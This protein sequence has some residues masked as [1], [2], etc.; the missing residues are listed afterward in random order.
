MERREFVKTMTAAG[1]GL[2]LPGLA[3]RAE[4]AKANA[5]VKRVLVMFKCHFDAGFI[6]TQYNVVHKR[7]F[8][9]FFPE[10]IEIARNANAGGKRRY[11]WTTGSWLVYE[12]LE[13]ASAA[14]RKTME[15]ALERGDIAWHG[16]P[17]TWQTEMISPSMI[18]G[19]VALARSL[20]R[21]FG[22]KTTGAKMTD[23]PGHTRGIVTPLARSGI[24]FLEIG[25]NDGSTPAELPPLFL[26]KDP[27]GADLA[28]MYHH[29]YGGVAV[30]PGAELAL[31]TAV[32]G[33]NSGPHTP[34]EIAKIYAE[35]AAQF[36]HAQISAASLSEMADALE[37]YRD[38]LPVV[39]Q[40]IGDTW[41]HGCASDPLKVARY[42]A[43]SR[44]RDAWIAQGKLQ[45]GDATDVN[46]LRHVLLEAEHTWGTDTKTWLDFDNYE[47]ADLARMLDTKNYK[48]VEFS[49]IEKRQDLLDG[50]MTLPEALR[51][52]AQLAVAGVTPVW[53]VASAKAVAVE[54]GKTIETAHF[55]LTID[56]KTGAI[57]TLRSKAS[58][59]EWA[60]TTNPIA[61]MT[62]QTL[63]P[64]DYRRFLSSYLTT[65]ADWAQKDFG[66]PNI[67]RYGA[68][69]EE[70]H[71]QRA[72]VTV[73]E[74]EGGHRV[75]VA[76]AF[77]DED[78]FRSGRAAF[79]QYAFVE[80]ELPQDEA[81][82]RLAVSWFG[83]PATR[84]PEALW[85]T[86]NP[87]VEDV[88]LWSLD[89]SGEAVSPF[90]VV[91]S[92][93]RHMHAV[94]KGFAHKGGSAQFAVE[95]LDAPVVALGERSA[96][97]FTNDQPDLSKG[98]HSC[99]FNNTWGTN[100]IM[101][102]GGDV[103]ARYVLRAG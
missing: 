86:F 100:Y 56:G 52:E 24:R 60:S 23:V 98:I 72:E 64:E 61:L 57:T 27:S 92:G 10:A 4:E 102:Y 33:D 91:K 87:V 3:L 95:T 67:E 71:P 74:S 11:V 54:A 37:P 77:V 5:D 22:R 14:D 38:K 66:K 103:K 65:K 85:L 82:I 40:E 39:N 53:P 73:E 13:Q 99:L 34:E 81:V 6:D 28:M 31:V 47:P 29:S 1:T 55:T 20:D 69:S 93:N 45:V 78:A 79:P 83:K 19:S 30:A 26:W 50:V 76:L 101:W 43:V 70:W 51:E 35:L 46:L 25:V 48:V 94:E 58:G 21:R 59:H 49:W 80:M 68:R 96:L 8:E 17:F 16:L 12:Y 90:E 62:Y 63:S 88:K 44:L 2:L 15:E 18:A 84:M 9:K 41:I 89:K 32:R 42:R 75:L 7:Y 97:L 36:P